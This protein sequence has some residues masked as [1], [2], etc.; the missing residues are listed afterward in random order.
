MTTG[1]VLKNRISAFEKRRMT[2]HMPYKC[3]L[4]GQKPNTYGKKLPDI[5][6]LDETNEPV[7]LTP[8]GRSLVGY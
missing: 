4:F 6:S 8:L 2:T 5:Q 3:K 7:S 1:R